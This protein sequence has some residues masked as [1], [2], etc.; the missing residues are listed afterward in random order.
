M[1]RTLALLL[2]CS[3]LSACTGFQ[4]NGER[5]AKNASEA[6]NNVSHKM[7]ELVTYKPPVKRYHPVHERYCYRVM[8]DV[9][10][11]REP[12]PDLGSTFIAYQGNAEVVEELPKTGSLFGNEGTV[13]GGGVTYTAPPRTETRQLVRTEPEGGMPRPQPRPI[14]APPVKEPGIDKAA[15]DDA[16]KKPEIS[17]PSK[18]QH[19]KPIYVPPAP[20]VKGSN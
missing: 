9:L 20:P 17:P 18:F 10:C 15:P 7:R 19:L 16:L 12:R 14:S 5:A 2:C 8:Q 3:A 13:T 1:N 4:E 6:M 11:Y